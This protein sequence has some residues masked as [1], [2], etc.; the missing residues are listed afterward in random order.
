L[1]GVDLY[2]L[3]KVLGQYVSSIFKS[4]TQDSVHIGCGMTQLS[5]VGKRVAVLSGREG[6]VFCRD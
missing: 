3:A 5:A 1:C 6:F 4:Q 2:F